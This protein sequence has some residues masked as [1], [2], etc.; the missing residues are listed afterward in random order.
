[1]VNRLEL[2]LFGYNLLNILSELTVL[3]LLVL[4]MFIILLFFYLFM[5]I[6]NL[7][8]AIKEEINY[9]L[10]FLIYNINGR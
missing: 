9:I 7:F 2:G 8:N 3:L 5:L 4:K 10:D 1:M 6:S